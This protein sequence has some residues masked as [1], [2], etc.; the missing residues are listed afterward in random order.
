LKEVERMR[1]TMIENKENKVVLRC[2]KCKKKGD[3]KTRVRSKDRRCPY[4]GYVGLPA[5]FEIQDSEESKS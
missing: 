3:I 4:C 5:E 2:P 1:E